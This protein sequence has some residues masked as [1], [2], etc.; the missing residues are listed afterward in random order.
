VDFFLL[1]FN[2]TPHFVHNHA[3]ALLTLSKLAGVLLS[4]KQG[5]KQEGRVDPVLKSPPRPPSLHHTRQLGLAPGLP[6]VSWD[7]HVLPKRQSPQQTTK[8][9]HKGEDKQ[10]NKNKRP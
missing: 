5:A 2:R 3:H 7:M 6:W 4:A 10:H 1:F 9:M 8:Q